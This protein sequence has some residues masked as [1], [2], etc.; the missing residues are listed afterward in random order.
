MFI[1]NG[2]QHMQVPIGLP[3]YG[4]MPGAHLNFTARPD[5]PMHKDEDRSTNHQGFIR[6]LLGSLRRQD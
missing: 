5:D 4:A 1:P 2:A 3:G 6:L